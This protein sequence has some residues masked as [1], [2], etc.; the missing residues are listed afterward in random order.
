MLMMRMKAVCLLASVALSCCLMRA[1]GT[2]PTFT[3][4]IA[5]QTYTL[6][7]QD[8]AKGGTTM[9]PTV[10]V[11]I[12]LTFSGKKTQMDAAQDA[13]R[14]LKSPIFANYRFESGEKTQYGDALLRATFPGGS[15]RTLLGKPEVKAITIDVPVGYGYLL[16]SKASGQSFAV[17]DSEYVEKELFQQIPKQDGKLVIAVTDNTTFYAAAD[18][19]VC[20]TWGTHGIDAA[21]GNSFV[22]GS[23]L[24]NAPAIVTDQDIQP[25]TQQLAE[26]FN[27][28]LHDP[29]S[30]F[31]TDNAPGN[32]FA[33]WQFPADDDGCGGSGI[34]TNYFLLEPT[35]T[36]L[37][38]NFPSSTQL[39][40]S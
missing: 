34:G 26:F 24:R 36:N 2:V 32:Y 5:G 22:L 6:A 11:P 23:Y 4:T 38:N 35:N 33:A 16:H 39:Q 28:P 21:T 14:I 1:Q 10:L 20:C 9:I 13:T 29:H 17:V 18:A 19:T 37:K 31:R 3:R 30:Y 27:D 25:L 8:P 15:G 12:K 7:G 40:L